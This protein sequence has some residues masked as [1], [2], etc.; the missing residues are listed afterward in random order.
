MLLTWHTLLNVLEHRDE[1]RDFIRSFGPFAP[2]VFIM[3]QALQVILSPIPGEA[4][5]LIG[6]FLFGRWLGLIYS[7]IGL[8]LGSLA[9]FLIARQFRKLVKP[10][11]RRSKYYRRLEGL[12]EHQGLFL[13]FLLF[14][15][16]GFPKDFLSYFLGLSRMPWQ[17]FLVIV[18]IGRIPGTLMLSWQGA[19]IYDGNIVGILTLLAITALVLFPAWYFRERIYRWVELHSLKD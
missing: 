3:I 7:S 1:I 10:W 14:V 11:L 8:T 17:I 9:A 15:F 13:C 19:N 12:L 18:A 5:G 2:V 6:G 4:T 16:P